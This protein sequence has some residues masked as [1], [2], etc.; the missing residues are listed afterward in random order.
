MLE[1]LNKLRNFSHA[2]K[3]ITKDKS[4]CLCINAKSN[5]EFTAQIMLTYAKCFE[6]LFN[7]EKYGAYTI[8]DLPISN[9][10]LKEKYIYL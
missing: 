4:L 6:S 1:K 7:K 2:G 8:F 3:V 10:L 9:I 5:P